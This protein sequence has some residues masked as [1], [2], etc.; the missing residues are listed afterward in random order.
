M[1]RIIRA[2]D[3]HEGTIISAV[4]ADITLHTFAEPATVIE[5]YRPYNLPSMI[6]LHLSNGQTIQG[7]IDTPVTVEPP[8]Y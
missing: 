1:G 8:K 5:H 6:T 4:G 7:P 2:V 3:A